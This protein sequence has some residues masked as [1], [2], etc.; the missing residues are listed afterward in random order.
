MIKI[1]LLSRASCDTEESVTKQQRPQQPMQQLD[2]TM[3]TT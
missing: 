2:K 1:L 3:F